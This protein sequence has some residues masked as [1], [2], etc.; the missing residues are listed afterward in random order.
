MSLMKKNTSGEEGTETEQ[1]VKER[2]AMKKTKQEG[3]IMTLAL[4]YF[5]EGSREMEH[6]LEEEVR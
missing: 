2:P 6:K 4:N 1:P 5:W 3:L